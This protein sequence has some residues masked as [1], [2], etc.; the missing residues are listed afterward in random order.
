MTYL[1]LFQLDGMTD[2]VSFFCI[3]VKIEKVHYV[4]D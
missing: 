2:P 4:N 1:K 3:V